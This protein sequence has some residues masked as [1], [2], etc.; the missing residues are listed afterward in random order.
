VKS[1][2]ALSWFGLLAAPFAFTAQHVTGIAITQARCGDMYV[3]HD[4]VPV[5]ALSIIVAGAALA[6]AVAGEVAAVLA[7]RR[8]RE[9]GEEPPA[10]RVHFVSVMGM[11]FT[12]LFIVIVLMT[13]LGS[14]ILTECVQS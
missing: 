9:A 3:F 6:V 4:G 8:T 1:A 13:G 10:S 7:W 14:I 11:T 2:A 5:N 12:P